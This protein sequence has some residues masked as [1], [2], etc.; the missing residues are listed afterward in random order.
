[1]KI[2]ALL[3]GAGLV[4]IASCAGPVPSVHHATWPSASPSA[5]PS[6]IV[7]LS[8]PGHVTGRIPSG[9]HARGPLP[10]PGC[11]PGGTDPVVSGATIDRT[12]CIRGYTSTV[13]PPQ[14]ETSR[15]K[16]SMYAAYGIPDGTVSELDHL[17]PLELGGNNDTAN[18]WPEVGRIP[19]PKDLVE[20]AL[21][22]AVCTHLITL[23]MAQTAIAADWT[24]ARSRLGV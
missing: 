10:D 15:T 8:D 18:L 2:I 22:A 1:M 21:R 5:S 19:N 14:S 13:R 6:G 24:T 16:R 23:D 11:T 7:I 9:C 20:N 4:V 12:I 3:A 17:I